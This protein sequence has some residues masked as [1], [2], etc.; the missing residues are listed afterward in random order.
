MPSPSCPE[1]G[2]TVNAQDEAGRTPLHEAARGNPNPAVAR[3]LLDSGADI[4][5]GDSRG[6]T[7]LHLAARFGT[8]VEVVEALLAAAALDPERTNDE[9]ASVWDYIAGNPNLQDRIDYLRS[10]M[11]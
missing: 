2:P 3:A 7:P 9:G 1:P 4:N 8:A 11:R 6:W 5:A 10:V